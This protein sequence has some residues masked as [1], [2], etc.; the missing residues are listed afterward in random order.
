[1]RLLVT[2]PSPGAEA[3]AAIIEA[4]GHEAIIAPLL[5]TEAIDWQLPSPLPPALMLTSAAAV[6]LGGPLL[7]ALRDLPVFVVGTATAAAARAA[8]FADVR[9]GPGTV[10]ALV[11]GIAR[12]GMA[13][14]LH[15]CGADTT[16]TAVPA[17]L[18]IVRC[19]AYRARLQPLDLLPL[20]DHVLLYS[21][22]TARQFASEIDRLGGRRAA[23]Q[24]AAISPETLAAAGPGWGAG[25]AA[26]TPDE[27]AL[28]ATIGLPCQK[29][30]E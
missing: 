12:S 10:Q 17:G 16:P 5:V 9:T 2:R 21:P 13:S 19:I 3:S 4:L 18:N 24:L 28:L 29:A 30:D 27:D 15:L 20:V 8:G 25:V 23:F 1:V 6:R 26:A 7:A 11:E 14:V 22:R